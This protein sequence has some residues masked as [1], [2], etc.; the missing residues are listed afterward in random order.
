[1]LTRAANA[2]V[3]LSTIV[4]DE[5]SAQTTH[6]RQF[7]VNGPAVALSPNAAETMTLA[8]HELTTN[9]LKYGALSSR[10]GLV[11]VRWRVTEKRGTSW[12]EF[13][14]REEGGPP[15]AVHPAARRRGFGSELITGRIPYELRGLGAY[16]I[17]AGGARCHLEFP[18][19][20]GASVLQTGAPAPTTVFG[21]ATD[22]SGE[23]DLSGKHVVVV[24]DDFYLATDTVRALRG[25]GAE[26]FGPCPNEAAARREIAGIELHGAVLDINLEGGRSFGLASELM[27]AGIPFI[28]ITGYDQGIIPQDFAGVIRLEKPVEFKR[29][30]GA[31]AEVMHPEAEARP[32]ES[33]DDAW[34]VQWSQ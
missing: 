28:F 23:A 14:W 19:S 22:M 24:E 32:P 26:V 21:G 5:L 12:L 15:Q 33:H 30:V 20:D 10:N 1:M 3:D 13:D 9:A 4:Q 31:L 2:T 25:A 29:I 6:A 11:R 16:E 18:L 27:A 7:E 17:E 8:I 34:N